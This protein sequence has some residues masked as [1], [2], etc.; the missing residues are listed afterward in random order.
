MYV[1]LR[2]VCVRAKMVSERAAAMRRE[3]CRVGR[4]GRRAR[5]DGGDVECGMEIEVMGES[6]SGRWGKGRVWSLGLDLDTLL[7]EEVCLSRR[8]QVEVDGGSERVEMGIY[9]AARRSGSALVV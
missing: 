1:A 8:W 9:S 4:W 6:W 2:F 7:V 5:I 3:R